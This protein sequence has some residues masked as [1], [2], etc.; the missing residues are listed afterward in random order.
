MLKHG[1]DDKAIQ[2]KLAVIIQETKISSINLET[3][4]KCWDVRIKYKYSYWDSLI[5]ASA[6]ENHCTVI[7]SED[8]QHN[9]I[10]DNS[11]R[12]VNPF[13]D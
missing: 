11:V 1:I 9:Q 13:I 10:I 5:L 7:Y 3:I 2:D 8:M 12:I 6:I 4:K